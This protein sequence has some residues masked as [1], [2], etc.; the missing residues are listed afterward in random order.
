MAF[1]QD[2]EGNGK[3]YS[4]ETGKNTHKDENG[5]RWLRGTLRVMSKM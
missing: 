2:L 3:R 5:G 1:E 4:T